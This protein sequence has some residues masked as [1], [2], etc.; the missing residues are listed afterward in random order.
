[1][2]LD[3]PAAKPAHL[4]GGTNSF[5]PEDI[6]WIAG[7]FQITDPRVAE[8]PF[9]KRGNINL[10]TYEV[11]DGRQEY[12]LQ[13]VNS[14]VFTMPH[15]VMQGMLASIEAQASAKAQML[16]DELWEPVTLIPT[17]SG[18]PYLDLSDPEGLSVW[19]LMVKIP[20]AVTYKSLSEV[21]GREAQLRLAEE[22]GKGIAIYSDLTSS[23]DPSSIEGSLP[24]YR[25]TSVYYGQFHSVMARNRSL[26]E[27]SG[28]PSDLIVRS[29]TEQHFLLALD[30]DSFMARTNDPDLMPFIELV[31]EREPFAMGLW[32]A[33][34]EARI[35]HTLIHGDTKIENFLFCADTG[36]VKSLVDLDTVMP[37][38]W[39]ADWG[40]LQRSMV[41]VAGE[42]ETDLS[43]VKVNRDVY[44]AVTRGF[45][46]SAKEITDGEIEMLVP[47]VEAIT[48]ELGLR[49][50][51]DYLRGD[52]YFQLGPEDPADLNKTRAM[53]QLTLYHSLVEFRPEAEALIASLR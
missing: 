3:T 7:Q 8:A 42:K 2:T 48:L 26:A 30:E 4:T 36:R 6:A 5:S 11:S 38:T 28:L 27:V 44:I 24:G 45:L 50:L 52:T 17:H 41:N 18:R 43:K 47:A 34:E 35:R 20:N 9:S 39:L 16:C 22:V 21:E 15:R 23:I 46:H 49:F 53:V 19:R 14:D 12:L 29:S 1:M 33:L 25:D 32:T 40:D 13:K 10:H 51:T 37:F 31:M